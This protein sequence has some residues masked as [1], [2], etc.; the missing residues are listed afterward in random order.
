MNHARTHTARSELVF[1]F[2]S[3]YRMKETMKRLEKERVWKVLSQH[4]CQTFRVFYDQEHTRMGFRLQSKN[5]GTEVQTK[6]S[7]NGYPAALASRVCVCTSLVLSTQKR[8]SLS[9]S[10]CKSHASEKKNTRRNGLWKSS[11]ITSTTLTLSQVANWQPCLSPWSS[12]SL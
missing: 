10:V 11:F 7:L 12:L 1:L 6:S 8:G 4:F 2:D 3:A 5:F 9:C